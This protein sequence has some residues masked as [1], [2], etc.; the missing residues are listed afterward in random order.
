MSKLIRFGVSMNEQLLEKFDQQ[1][2]KK[3]YSNRSEAVRDLIRNQLVQLEWEDENQEVAGTVTLVYDHHVRGLTNV[4]ME[5]QH[6]FHNLVL[7]TMHVHLDH[8]N[9]LEVL[10]IKGK[11]SD[12]R[13]LAEKLISIKGVKH[14]QLSITSTGK[15]LD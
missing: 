11:A 15:N 9:C 5:I 8:Y 3:G 14:G 6:D 4:L 12:T 2:V 7:S 1:I 10:V 13:K